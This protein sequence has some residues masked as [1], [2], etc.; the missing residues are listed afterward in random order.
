VVVA[1]AASGKNAATAATGSATLATF[2]A[3][4]LLKTRDRKDGLVSSETAVPEHLIQ[5]SYL[6]PLNKNDRYIKQIY[7]YIA[8][9]LLLFTSWYGKF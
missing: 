9:S 4:F 6:F 5:H 7:D 2:R 8:K 3:F 1:I